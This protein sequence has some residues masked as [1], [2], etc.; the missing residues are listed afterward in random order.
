M[1]LTWVLYLGLSLFMIWAVCELIRQI[2]YEKELAEKKKKQ[3]EEDERINAT[4]R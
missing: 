4:F 1:S 3:Q 2:E